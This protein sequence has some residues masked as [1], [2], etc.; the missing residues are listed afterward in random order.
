ML[1][2]YDCSLNERDN[3][4]MTPLM[5]AEAH[6]HKEVA[7]ELVSAGARKS[8]RRDL[9]KAVERMVHLLPDLHRKEVELEAKAMEA[10][11]RAEHHRVA[12]DRKMTIF[13]S[14]SEKREERRVAS[15][16]ATRET[17]HHRSQQIDALGREVAHKC[18]TIGQLQGR[19]NN[20]ERDKRLMAADHAVVTATLSAQG[21]EMDRRYV[22]L[23][24]ERLAS[25]GLHL[26]ARH[27]TDVKDL[28]CA[29]HADWQRI[30]AQYLEESAA[31]RF[32][33][34]FHG[35][36]SA[37]V[38]LLIALYSATRGQDAEYDELQEQVT[39]LVQSTT[40]RLELERKAQAS[41]RA[42]SWN[43][44]LRRQAAP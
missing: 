6:G 18:G 26:L 3:N 1:L 15:Q 20:L 41:S 42:L 40:A 28:R 2:Q 33:A 9:V 32:D 30:G 35:E 37:R 36:W 22:V 38:S 24:E 34:L 10:E 27:G 7:K 11:L 44:R 43:A 13:E 29:E 19:I 5:V 8:S 21:S 14:R 39:F 25:A 16:N 12:D 17:I 4:G 23:G 31:L